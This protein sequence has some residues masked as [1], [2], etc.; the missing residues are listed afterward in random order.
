MPRMCGTCV[1][2]P[3]LTKRISLNDGRLEEIM[4]D[5]VKG[6]NQIC[7]C[8]KEGENTICRGVRDYTITMRHRLGV[9]DEPTEECLLETMEQVLNHKLIQNESL[10][11]KNPKEVSSR[12]IC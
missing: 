3:D 12:K 10:T 1:L 4:N 11:S 5:A 8:A 2:H 6:I 7:H 9:I